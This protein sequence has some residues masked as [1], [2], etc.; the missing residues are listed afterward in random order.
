MLD[1]ERLYLP[2]EIDWY[3]IETQLLAAGSQGTYHY[4]YIADCLF[5]PNDDERCLEIYVLDKSKPEP[6][7]TRFPP[8]TVPGSSLKHME[9]R[10]DRCKECGFIYD[11]CWNIDVQLC[12]QMCAIC[13]GRYRFRD[14]WWALVGEY[15]KQIYVAEAQ[16]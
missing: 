1:R 16:K 14:C 9:K 12:L 2:S 15:S 3:E 4:N 5:Q 6:E 8:T 13:G 7:G 10:D 11:P